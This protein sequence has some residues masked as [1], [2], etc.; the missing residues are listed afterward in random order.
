MSVSLGPETSVLLTNIVTAV[1]GTSRA[2]NCGGRDTLVFYFQGVGVIS[3]G[4]IVIEEAYQPV[5]GP[6]Y[7]GTWSVIGTPVAATS[8]TGNVQVATHLPIQAYSH[9]RVR[10]TADIAGGGNVTVALKMQ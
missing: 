10:V 5:D 4:S 3:G 9:V 8:L 7:A 1:S 6:A 2:V